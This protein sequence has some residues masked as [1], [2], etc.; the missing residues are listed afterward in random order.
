MLLAPASG[1][2]LNSA[3]EK[4]FKS[5]E[6]L[7]LNVK[8]SR[9]SSESEEELL[10]EEQQSAQPARKRSRVPQEHQPV[11]ARPGL[12]SRFERPPPVN[13]TSSASES[14]G[15]ASDDESDEEDQGWGN[16]YHV[17]RREIEEGPYVPKQRNGKKRNKDLDELEL[18]P[19]KAELAEALRLQRIQRASLDG[20][21]FGA[22][23]ALATPTDVESKPVSDVQTAF[24]TREAAI[25]YLLQS[26][27]LL[28]S[29]LTDFTDQT[30]HSHALESLLK[31]LSPASPLRALQT[32]HLQV[33]QTYLAVCAFWFKLLLEGKHEHELGQS[34]FKRLVGL[35]EGM[36]GLQDAGLDIDEANGQDGE[37]VDFDAIDGLDEEDSQ[38]YDMDE[39]I[40]DD[41]HLHELVQQRDLLKAL[42][43]EGLSREDL[44]AAR[45]GTDSDE[46][47]GTVEAEKPEKKKRK[48]RGKRKGKQMQ[49]DDAQPSSLL[50]SRPQSRDDYLE[51]AALSSADADAKKATKHSL[52]FHTSQI[53]STAN[54]RSTA[55]EARRQ[56][57]DMDVPYVSKEQLRREAQ[58]KAA[59]RQEK[60]LR[61]RGQMPDQQSDDGEGQTPDEGDDGYY[62]LI[63]TSKKA[64][65]QGKKDAYDEQKMA[66]RYAHFHL[67][68]LSL[69]PADVYCVPVL[70][71][72]WKSLLVVHEPS[73]ALSWPTKV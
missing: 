51:P 58:R 57:G 29:L 41:D 40:E 59:A 21:D 20:D 25:A 48:K 12:S 31:T 19:D 2:R 49:V 23:S 36:Q 18:D 72:P 55:A 13:S 7:P 39:M 63:Q 1:T 34:V 46:A 4:V 60:E 47:E 32:L 56:G 14:S 17:S 8:R 28:L 64:A 69:S 67:L 9:A 62:D 27:P 70:R 30:Q 54:R 3:L 6:V 5:N 53:A 45:A 66:D 33:V 73:R 50:L 65:K 37:D 22:V 71:C 52:R 16:A 43:R 61:A 26:N 24:D 15:S 38:E 68:P 35:R 42:E 10:D 11:Q 44:E